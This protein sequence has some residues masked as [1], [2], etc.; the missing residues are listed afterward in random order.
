MEVDKEIGP[1][2]HRPSE[3][4]TL[5]A[6]RF[7]EAVSE[8]V[9]HF[10]VDAD[11]DSAME[12]VKDADAAALIG[13][14]TSTLDTISNC[15]DDAKVQE[16]GEDASKTSDL[17]DDGIRLSQSLEAM[18][19]EEKPAEAVPIVEDTESGAHTPI[20]MSPLK[21]EEYV[22]HVLA[23]GYALTVSLQGQSNYLCHGLDGRQTHWCAYQAQA[24]AEGRGFS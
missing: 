23:Y 13:P 1:V 19:V 18:S 4:P 7:L 5:P 24:V 11:G 16:P 8:P 12:D 6:P 15:G 10:S 17:D 9:A 22:R 3:S 2:D 20:Q 14:A 21:A